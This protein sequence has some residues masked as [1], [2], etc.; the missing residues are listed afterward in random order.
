MSSSYLTPQDLQQIK[1]AV[2]LPH[3]VV[4]CRTNW[5]SQIPSYR[6]TIHGELKNK[7][8]TAYPFSDSSISHCR[9]LGGFAFSVYDSGHVI[10]LGFDLEETDRVTTEI[11]RRICL[12][13]EEF[14]KAPSPASLWSAKEAAFK[15]L[16]GPQQ[17]KTVSELELTDWR[18]LGSQSET[19]SVKDPRSFNFFSIQG[20]VFRK[21]LYTLAIF[22]ARP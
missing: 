12:T 6:D 1:G 11:A 4:D 3:L 17:P 16:K 20:L 2:G 21:N 10:S 14:E 19:A 7:M 8:A 22:V 13:A 5:G 15:T 18:I 9:T